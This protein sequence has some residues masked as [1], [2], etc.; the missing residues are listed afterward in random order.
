MIRSIVF[1]LSLV[2]AGAVGLATSLFLADAALSATITGTYSVDYTSPVSL[3]GADDFAVWGGPSLTAS[4]TKGTGLIN[5]TLQ[6]TRAGELAYNGYAAVFG[7][8]SSWVPGGI[9]YDGNQFGAGWELSLEEPTALDGRSL[10]MWILTNGPIGVSATAYSIDYAGNPVVSETLGLPA[11]KY[12]L[13]NFTGTGLAGP[14]V[15]RLTGTTS[16]SSASAQFILGGAA[17]VPLAVPEPEYWL[18]GLIVAMGLLAYGLFMSTLG[19][20]IRGG[21]GDKRDP[22]AG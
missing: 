13:L 20:I 7:T 9:Y 21:D 17:L 8:G 16:V 18:A 12:S 5:Y 1:A 11:F 10:R 3:V 6:P 2:V 19:R 14:V 4:A 15:V 22:P